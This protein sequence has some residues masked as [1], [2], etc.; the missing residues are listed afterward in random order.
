VDGVRRPA[1]IRAALLALVSIDATGHCRG[2]GDH[3]T[4]YVRRPTE[5]KS[6]LGGLLLEWRLVSR[7]AGFEQI[8]RAARA[9]QVLSSTPTAAEEVPVGFIDDLWS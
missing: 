4:V 3:A 8:R 7:L 6:H 2:T 5:S 9:V 1:R